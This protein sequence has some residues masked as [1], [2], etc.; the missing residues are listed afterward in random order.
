MATIK[1]STLKATMVTIVKTSSLSIIDEMEFK[2]NIQ[3]C[4]PGR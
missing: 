2:P 1:N 4:K 3:T